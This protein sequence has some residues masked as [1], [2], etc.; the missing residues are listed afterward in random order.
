MARYHERLLGVPAT[1]PSPDYFQLLGLAADEVDGETIVA[2]LEERLDRLERAAPR[3]RGVVQHLRRVLQR[4]RATLLDATSRAAHLEETRQ[5]RLRELKRWLEASLDDMRRLTPAGERALLLRM[6]ALGLPQDEAGRAIDALLPALGAERLEGSPSPGAVREA[7]E[8]LLLLMTEEA[9]ARLREDAGVTAESE[10]IDAATPPAPEAEAP[11]PVE[12]G[13]A[14]EASPPRG[15]GRRRPAAAESAVHWKPQPAAAAVAVA[16]PP[17]VVTRA[18]AQPAEAGHWTPKKA[19]SSEGSTAPAP[20][21]VAA[22]V[23]ERRARRLWRTGFALFALAAAFAGGDLL[24]AFAPVQ[25]TWFDERTAPLRAQALASPDL[26]R[27]LAGGAAA[28][29]LLAGLLVWLAGR[30]AGR[31]PFLA[32]LALL[33]VPAVWAGLHPIGHERD[34]LHQRAA[35]G[36]ERDA[37]AAAV[38]SSAAGRA[39][40]DEER[41][42]A[43]A[44]GAASVAA[45]D[46]ARADLTAARAELA[47]ARQAAQ[48]ERARLAR[49]VAD[50]DARLAAL[51]RERDALAAEKARLEAAAAPEKAPEAPPA[52]RDGSEKK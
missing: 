2:A 6:E 29:L 15:V 41:A 43:L 37:L 7:D 14:P 8:R 5:R 31:R 36:A 13:P 49:Q 46:S 52:P 3:D 30:C 45:L 27:W 19:P 38:R 10:A 16:E 44:A 34:L 11:V 23:D 50:R 39:L 22:P 12:A 40:L 17:P 25:A 24:A 26:P 32:P 51:R 9:D 28:G 48:A 1:V 35:L 42:A 47:T 20:A 18:P 21:P 33:C 4:A